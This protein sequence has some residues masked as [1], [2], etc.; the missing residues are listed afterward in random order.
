MI[1][2]S[3]SNLPKSTPTSW[4][5]NYTAAPEVGVLIWVGS[6]HKRANTNIFTLFSSR[7]LSLRG[8][9]AN[10][11]AGSLLLEPF[12]EPREEKSPFPRIL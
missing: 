9:F 5:G 8:M 10:G 11:W 4:C 2:Y 7:L 1:C 12:Q 3:H 6:E